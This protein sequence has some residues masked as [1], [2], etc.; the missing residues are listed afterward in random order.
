MIIHPF[1]SCCCCVCCYFWWCYWHFRAFIFFV[2]PKCQRDEWTSE[3]MH[4][5]IFFSSDRNS[6]LNELDLELTST[7]LLMTWFWI[8]YLTVAERVTHC[9]S[10]LRGTKSISFRFNKWFYLLLLVTVTVPSSPFNLS[11]RKRMTD[12]LSEWTPSSTVRMCYAEKWFFS[13]THFFFGGV[14][15]VYLHRHLLYMLNWCCHCRNDTINNRQP[16][17]M[18]R[19]NDGKTVFR[20]HSN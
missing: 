18:V 16:F 11:L 1:D 15:H 13:F 20:I 7:L 10:T 6:I 2:R 9:T 8:R 19:A 17:T 12:W 3:I 14:S 4:S 5:E